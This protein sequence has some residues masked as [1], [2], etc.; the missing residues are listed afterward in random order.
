[1]VK[2]VSLSP[3]GEFSEIVI[4]PVDK[5]LDQHDPQKTPSYQSKDLDSFLRSRV[6]N[7]EH[8]SHWNFVGQMS[9]SGNMVCVWGYTAGN[10]E[11]AHENTYKL[12]NKVV[13][14]YADMLFVTFT[15]LTG[16]LPI[17]RNMV[18]TQIDQAQRILSKLIKNE[19]VT[20]VEVATVVIEPKKAQPIVVPIVKKT[21]CSAD[22]VSGTDKKKKVT[23]CEEEDE[24]DYIEVEESEDDSDDDF[25]QEDDVLPEEENEEEVEVEIEYD[26][27]EN[28]EILKDELELDFEKYD[29]PDD[30]IPK[31]MTN[32]YINHF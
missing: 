31:T 2:I 23:I 3:N 9:D 32:D 11:N 19:P 26:D 27:K 4:K 7:K 6:K 15:G 16:G 24:S 20:K 5:T 18:D 21:V 30:V 8:H 22:A 29:Y 13:R 10:I 25:M 28:D 14:L 17:M 12:N 1:M